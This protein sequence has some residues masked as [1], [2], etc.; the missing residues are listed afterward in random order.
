MSIVFVLSVK[1]HYKIIL[2]KKCISENENCTLL[3]S[4]LISFKALIK[5]VSVL[6]AIRF[7][8]HLNRI[9]KNLT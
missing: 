7:V 2:P 1:S 9:K 6:T 3:L 8:C 4:P 5:S